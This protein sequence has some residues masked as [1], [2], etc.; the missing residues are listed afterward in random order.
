MT[1]DGSTHEEAC[2]EKAGEVSSSRGERG[3]DGS[4]P[5]RS[6]LSSYS[7]LVPGQ[8]LRK[9]FCA[10]LE[11]RRNTWMKDIFQGLHFT[12]RNSLSLYLLLIFVTGGRRTSCISSP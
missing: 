8:K 1:G 10:S 7:F 9:L 6:D 3:L 2:P 4:Y 11:K 5:P 12:F